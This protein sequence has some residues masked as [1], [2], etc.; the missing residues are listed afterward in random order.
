MYTCVVGGGGGKVG[1]GGGGGEENITACPSLR[2]T[3]LT[4]HGEVTLEMH[5]HCLRQLFFSSEEK[6]EVVFRCSYFTLPCLV[7]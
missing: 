5:V 6:K 4:H 3:I 2:G 7:D 1:G